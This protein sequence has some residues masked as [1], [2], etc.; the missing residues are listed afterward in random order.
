MFKKG[1]PVF[2]FAGFG[3]GGY[4]EYKCLPDD[5]EV[6]EKGLEAIK[7]ANLTYEEAAAV[8]GG[9]LTALSLI[10]KGNICSGQKVLIYGASGAIGT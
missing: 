1:A 9:G 7:P 3:F 10:R 4:A 8:P 2:A 5:G 6:V